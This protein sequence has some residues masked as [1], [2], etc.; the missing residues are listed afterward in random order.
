MR[1]QY[2]E[3]RNPLSREGLDAAETRPLSAGGL[4]Y[5]RIR[6]RPILEIYSR[7][8]LFVFD[9]STHRAA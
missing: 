4:A 8:E 9:I 6:G 2:L 7:R 5:L 1:P 3:L